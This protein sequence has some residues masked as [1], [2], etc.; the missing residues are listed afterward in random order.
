[1]LAV[2]PKNI[3][4][5]HEWLLPT[6]IHITLLPHTH[7]LRYS[8][9]SESNGSIAVDQ[10]SQESVNAL[11]DE[12]LGEVRFGRLVTS[13]PRA[14]AAGLALAPGLFFLLAGRSVGLIGV[15]STSA[16][17]I[18]SLVLGLTL[19]NIF[20]LLGGSS[21]RG[22]TSSLVYESLGSF[23]G[24]LSG[25]TLMG[26]YVALSVAMM[27]VS[28]NLLHALF[29]LV[30][31]SPV[32]WGFGI[33]IFL[34]LIQ[35]FRTLPKRGWTLPTVVALIGA[36]GVLLIAAVPSLDRTFYRNPPA[37]GSGELMQTAVLLMA[38]FATLEAVMVSR[39]LIQDPEKRLPSSLLWTLFISAVVLGIGQIVMA[40]MSVFYSPGGSPA[41][42]DALISGTSLAPWFIQAAIILGLLFATN[43]SF[44]TGARELHMLTRWGAFPK[45]FLSVRAPFRLPPL[46]FAA[47]G[48]LS[49]P[50][51]IWTPTDRLVDIA[52]VLMLVP[53]LF[54]NIAA[55]WSKRMEPDRRRPFL[56]PFYPL[57][58]L[59]ALSLGIALLFASP[60]FGTL[61]GMGW[62]I[63][64]VLFYQVYA[65][66]HLIEALEGVR[67]FGP[68]PED[69]KKDGNYRILVPL[70]A[71]V[72]R[73][74]VLELATG[75]ANQ[76]GGELI[77]LQVVVIP[78]PLAVEQGQRLAKERNTL[79]K[80]S[81]RFAANLGIP[82]HPITRLARSV[83]EGILQ[84][85]VE[86][87]CD[88]IFLSWSLGETPRSARLG[89]VLDPVIRSAS[90]DVVLLAF[91]PDLLHQDQDRQTPK[92]SQGQGKS[93]PIDRILVTTA[94]GPHAPLASRLALH[95]AREYN[96]T[97][98]GVYI[99]DPDASPEAIVEGN[100]RIEKTLQAMRQQ[101]KDLPGATSQH[102]TEEQLTFESSV[103]KAESVLEGIVQ[104]GSESDLVLIGASEE[105]LIDQVLFGTLPEDVARASPTPV[106]MVKRYRGLRRFWLERLWGAIYGIFPTLTSAERIDVYRRVRRNARPDVDFFV[107]IGLSAIIASYGL[108]QDSSAVIIG[109]MLVAPLFTPIQ[110]ISLAIVRGDIH[111]LRL[112][113]ESALKGIVLAIGVAILITAISPLRSI[114]QEISSRVSP[115]LFD[116]AVA[117]ASGAAGA[118]AVARKDVAASLPGVAIAA[119]LVP[120][121]GV[122]GIGLAIPD[123]QIA[124]G[125]ALLFLTNL[126]AIVLAGAVILL[127]IGFRPA[128]RDEREARLR[129]GLLASLGLLVL[130]TV[131]LALVFSRTVQD[132]RIRQALNQVI[133]QQIDT[134]DEIQLLDFDQMSKAIDQSVDLTL[135]SIPIQQ[136]QSSDP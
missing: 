104:A 94:G 118:Y 66:N 31:L 19:L 64:G 109:G 16:V 91:Q 14:A 82:V 134:D 38:I 83:H 33:L 49:V 30:L 133:H 111:L 68:R 128:D 84:T 43:A 129:V 69:E 56:V 77:A 132:S 29:P 126:V 25:F 107:M 22:G 61:G 41:V 73:R 85:A 58:P 70:T 62:I 35:I 15:N 3:S 98:S 57:V 89:R 101:A 131:P 88:L 45:S 95:L 102:P 8:C 81:T 87:D 100:M 63:I 86:E 50:F 116:L 28:A 39:R 18:V 79:F 117:L 110:A 10:E 9:D 90:C 26:G 122:V 136:V 51:L 6:A 93:L 103:V 71:G 60:R 114:G 23:S 36:L 11:N 119:A 123:A 13:V 121:L 125:G 1:L 135:I 46:I 96:A 40:G 130:I 20:E 44:M 92:E 12:F 97:T 4:C 53:V 78:D 42:L 127:L 5:L 52:V 106:L 17:I 65:R 76:M 59:V 48:T 113:I 99:V 21:A 32:S 80:W 124:G 67:V 55:M 47:L 120:P 27:Q 2:I 105:S 75:L 54:I 72:E 115:N 34:C 112:A 7:F 74:A 108:L 24:Y 37:M